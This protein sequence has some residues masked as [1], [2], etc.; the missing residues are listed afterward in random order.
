VRELHRCGRGVPGQVDVL[1]PVQL[2]QVEGRRRGIPERLQQSLY[3]EFSDAASAKAY[4]DNQA[5]LYKTLIDDTLVVVAGTG[6]PAVDM[7]ADR[8]HLERQHRKRRTA[9]PPHGDRAVLRV[10]Q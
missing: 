2:L 1:P 3:V 5:I 9:R 6:L 10:D 7:A 4:A 8:R